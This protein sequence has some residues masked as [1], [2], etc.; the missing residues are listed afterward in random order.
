MVEREV[1]WSQTAIEQFKVLIFF[2]QAHDVNEKFRQY[3]IA[4]IDEHI[5]VILHFPKC[6][7]PYRISKIREFVFDGFSLFY[8]VKP[9]KII[10]YLFWDNRQDPAK[11]NYLLSNSL[12]N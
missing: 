8:L 4:R 12:Y 7:K 6:G 11:L 1:I 10:I 3:T 2:W 5:K 9:K